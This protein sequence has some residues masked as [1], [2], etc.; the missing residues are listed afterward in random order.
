MLLSNYD[1]AVH[2]IS[3]IYFI[4]IK[5]CLLIVWIDHIVVLLCTDK[6]YFNDKLLS[7]NF[8]YKIFSP[9]FIE[10]CNYHMPLFIQWNISGFY[11]HSIILFTFITNK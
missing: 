11:V 8:N 2:Y 10:K 4:I 6:I 3:I 9:G 1:F 5:D 7:T